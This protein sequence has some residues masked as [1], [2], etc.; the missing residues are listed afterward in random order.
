ML[1]EGSLPQSTD[2]DP[3]QPIQ[4]RVYDTSIE[5]HYGT[6]YFIN[7]TELNDATH[8]AV[9][10]ALAGRGILPV[11]FTRESRENATNKYP[12]NAKIYYFSNY[13][14]T[15]DTIS[16][17]SI[18]YIEWLVEAEREKFFLLI[19]CIDYLRIYNEMQNLLMFVEEL[20]DIVARKKAILIIPVYLPAFEQQEVHL[21]ERFGETISLKA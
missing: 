18:K 21:L 6:R 15:K 13:I 3:Y 14:K 5:L 10:H 9:A 12:Q 1:K 16:P 2:G 8:F 20:F 4:I 17:L 7:S 11:I 19:D